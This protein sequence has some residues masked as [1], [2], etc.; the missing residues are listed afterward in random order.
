MHVVLGYG[1]EDFERLFKVLLSVA[2]SR[3][4]FPSPSGLVVYMITS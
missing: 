1:I 3:Y 4:M 2:N